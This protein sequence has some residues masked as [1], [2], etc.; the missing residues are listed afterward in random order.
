MIDAVVI[1]ELKVFSGEKGKVMHM[2]RSS[3]DVFEKFGEIYFSEVLPRTVK[4]WKKHL[5]MTQHF[6][7]PKGELKLVMFDSRENSKT[8]GEIQEVLLGEDHYKMVRIPPE[9]CYS[10]KAT[11]NDVALIANCTDI[12]HDD[13]EVIDIDLFAPE[14]PYKWE[15]E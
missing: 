4:G 1:K 14:I 15:M 11:S 3:D 8:N 10:F 7:V 12:E 5:K 6:V 2:L 9:V 13:E